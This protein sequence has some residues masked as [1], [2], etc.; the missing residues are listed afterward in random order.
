MSGNNKSIQKSF[1]LN[2]NNPDHAKIFQKLQNYNK[3][4]Y[5]SESMLI[6]EALK[7][8]VTQIPPEFVTNE[9]AVEDRVVHESELNK[10]VDDLKK[11]MDETIHREL[12]GMIL[13]AAGMQRNVTSGSV[14]KDIFRNDREVTDEETKK[15]NEKEA[16][17]VLRELTDIWSN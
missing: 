14:D 16:E 11:Y 6:V 5:K 9:N 13:G 1:R 2:M 4:I 15:K 7:Y 8:F 10:V 17:N 12:I 3:N